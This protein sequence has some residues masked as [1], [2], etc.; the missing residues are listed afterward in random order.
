MTIEHARGLQEEPAEE[1]EA[2]GRVTLVK[3]E[4]S[5]VRGEQR[6]RP[7]VGD[8]IRAGDVFETASEA[9]VGIEHAGHTVVLMERARPTC[10]L[11]LTTLH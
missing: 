5:L 6:S 2:A 7:A 4:V 11:S 1:L 9:S 3:G 8:S 10:R